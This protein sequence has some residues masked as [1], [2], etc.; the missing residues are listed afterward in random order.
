MESNNDY[1]KSS[2]AR[3]QPIVFQDPFADPEGGVGNLTIVKEASRAHASS[4]AASTISAHG[5]IFDRDD[6]SAAASSMPSTTAISRECSPSKTSPEK[7]IQGDNLSISLPPRDNDFI[8]PCAELG[9]LDE[10]PFASPAS[11][12]STQ[13]FDP[14][15]TPR[16]CSNIGY[17]DRNASFD[18]GAELLKSYGSRIC[19]LTASYLA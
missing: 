18:G 14:D 5:A 7:S 2:P 3:S 16:S 17:H 11:F 10:D 1:K 13:S 8:L 6:D 15:I 9:P 4:N 12:G 19:E